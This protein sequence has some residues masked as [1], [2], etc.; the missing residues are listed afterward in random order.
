MTTLRYG[1]PEWKERERAWAQECDH[2]YEAAAAD[3]VADGWE[4]REHDHY[5]AIFCKGGETVILAR[6]LGNSGPWYPTSIGL[7]EA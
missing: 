7:K 2:A 6:R 1:T 3:L 5:P 4:R